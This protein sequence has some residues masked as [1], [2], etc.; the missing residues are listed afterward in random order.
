MREWGMDEERT[1]DEMRRRSAREGSARFF[2]GG[3]PLEA[4]P[5]HGS[6]QPG[7]VGWDYV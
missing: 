5:A 7:L 3:R 4:V 1:K 6:A 2:H